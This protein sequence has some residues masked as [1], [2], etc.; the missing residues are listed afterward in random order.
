M[1]NNKEIELFSSVDE[2]EI[3]QVSS[4]L[5]E[6]NI[7]FIRKDDGSGSYMNLYMGQSIQAKR[8]FINEG[9]FEKAKDLLASFLQ[10]E[11]PEENKDTT[12]T[13]KYIMIRRIF[14]FLFLI[15]PILVILL[16]IIF[17]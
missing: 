13:N 16:L 6:H 3:K 5:A 14:G 11:K 15:M 9:D 8:I 17:S 2:Y 7:P 10:E 1:E 4:I 12:P